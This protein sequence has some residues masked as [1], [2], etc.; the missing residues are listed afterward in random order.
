MWSLAEINNKKKE[1]LKRIRSCNNQEE[2][3]RLEISLASYINMLENSGT[4]RYT[5]FYNLMD[6]VTQ[7]K[8]TLLKPS[9]R[10]VVKGGEIATKKKDY[11]DESY[12]EFLLQ[13][14][15]N[16]SNTDIN[17]DSENGINFSNMELSNEELVKI[18]KLFYSS[19]NDKEIYDLAKKIL[20]DPTALNFS[21]DYMNEYN[22]AGGITFPDYAFDK[23]YC[24]TKRK[25]TIFDVQA[26]NHEVMHG[27][28]FYMKPKIPTKTYYGFHETSTY[29]IDYLFI[30]YLESLDIDKSEVQ[31]LR[32]Q[33]DAYLVGLANLVT[34]QVQ[35]ELMRKKGLMYIKKHTTKDI[36]EV[37]NPDIIKNLLEVQSG[38]IAFGLNNQIRENKDNGLHNLKT[39]MK[40]YISKDKRPNFEYIGLSDEK[41]LE[42]SKMIGAYSKEHEQEQGKSR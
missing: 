28:D 24:T 38:V 39:F 35:N 27:I 22:Q 31:K 13:I 41:L 2:K 18:S 9:S 15:N 16:V 36:L 23:V 19:L 14:A 33:K 4:I 25:N 11:M 7:G 21:D 6:K 32:L 8:F 26:N 17:V 40:N 34:M 20:D 29:A 3:E 37:L 42:L 12:L 30:D 5:K 1:A 10:L